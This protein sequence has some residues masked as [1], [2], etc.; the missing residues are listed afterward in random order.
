MH[1][2]SLLSFLAAETDETSVPVA[3]TT[4]R[5]WLGQLGRAA[6]AGLPLAGL[7]ATPAA[8]GT[9]DTGLDALLLLL[10]FEYLQAAL[11][12]QALAASGLVPAAQ[13]PDVQRLL[14]HQQQHADFLASALRNAGATVPTAAP[15]YDFTGSQGGTRPARFPGVLTDFDRFLAL[16]QQIEDA[17]VRTYLGQA[18][19]LAT[20]AALPGT[21]ALLGTVLRLQAV[22]SRHA[23]HL[24]TLRRQRGAAAKP[25]PSAADVAPTPLLPV[26][27]PAS[28]AAPVGVYDGETNVIQLY[29]GLNRLP[30]DTLFGLGSG[31]VVQT[32]ALAEA[33]DEPL[34]AVEANRVLNLFS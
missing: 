10:N 27:D 26:S 17:G 21:A 13:R 7:L 14:L 8:A 33:F 2:P 4:R 20:S 19:N 5:G 30:F 23:A 6:A 15:R 3:A 1:L 29:N 32:T 22:E 18:A 34:G 16:A 24:R 31:N 25:W 9:T 11:Y 12:T 28:T